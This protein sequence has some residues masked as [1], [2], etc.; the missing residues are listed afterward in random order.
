[1]ILWWSAPDRHP[2]AVMMYIRFPLWLRNVKDL[3]HERA[4]DIT[5]ETVRFWW[6]REKTGTRTAFHS[7]HTTRPARQPRAKAA[8]GLG[9]QI[10]DPVIVAERIACLCEVAQQRFLVHAGALRK[11]AGQVGYPR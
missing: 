1:M 4:I 2:F 7:W 6:N 8:F 3:L 9:F 5:H 10:C 11:V